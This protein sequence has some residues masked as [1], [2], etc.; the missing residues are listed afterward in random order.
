MNISITDETTHHHQQY[1]PT[2][3]GSHQRKKTNTSALSTRSLNQ[4][5][6]MA[7]SSVINKSSA[8]SGRSTPYTILPNSELKSA[9]KV[10][11]GSKK[12]S[13]LIGQHSRN[14]NSK[15]GS[16][17]IET[18]PPVM[19]ANQ[20][21]IFAVSKKNV[22]IGNQASKTAYGQLFATSDSSPGRSDR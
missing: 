12:R 2:S 15:Q 9:T 6:I 10:V 21:P 7:V 14:Q 5:Q 3:A 22:L 16:Y 4:S 19:K 11:A 1:N 18:V 13:T 17:S 8:L 20:A